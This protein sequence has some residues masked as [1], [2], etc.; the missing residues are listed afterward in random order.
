MPNQADKNE[1]VR[2]PRV[3]PPVY[4]LA[5]IIGM[6]ALHK[7]LPGAILLD[8]PLRWLG[9]VPFIG[10]LALG[11]S[12][13]RL[14]RKYKTTIKPGDTSTHLMTDGPYRFT[15]NPIYLGMVAL[16]VGVALMLGSLTPW[17]IAPAFVWVI[18]RNIIP[19]EEAM[20]AAAF[21]A[22]YEQYRAHTRRWL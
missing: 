4:L 5:A 12:A 22:E 11:G 19:V 15:R 16:L 18:N 9:F 2:P 6:V 20:M 21:G 1:L 17:L 10:G 3:M 8:S 7:Y 14:F 13:V